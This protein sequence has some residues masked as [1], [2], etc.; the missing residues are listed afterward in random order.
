MVLLRR[1]L[2]AMKRRSERL[3]RLCRALLTDQ[4]MSSAESEAGRV[5]VP[6]LKV[7][8]T[9]LVAKTYRINVR[10]YDWKKLSRRDSC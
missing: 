1:K 5:T 10:N 3:M 8:S 6:L 4:V 7:T 2:V 9:M